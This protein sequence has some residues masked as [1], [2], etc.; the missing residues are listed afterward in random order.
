MWKKEVTEEEMGASPTCHPGAID[1][2][3][4]LLLVGG[5]F[6]VITVGALITVPQQQPN[7]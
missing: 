4:P 3:C 1:H 7:R 5:D 6:N 2:L